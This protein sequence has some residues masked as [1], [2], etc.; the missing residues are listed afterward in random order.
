V[1]YLCLDT[2]WLHFAVHIPEMSSCNYGLLFLTHVSMDTD[3]TINIHSGQGP[4]AVSAHEVGMVQVRVLI[5][6][7]FVEIVIVRNLPYL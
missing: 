4:L 1:P 2:A 3:D 7:M 6:C 5:G